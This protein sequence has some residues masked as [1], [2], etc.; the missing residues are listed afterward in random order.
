MIRFNWPRLAL[1]AK[2]IDERT[3]AARSTATSGEELEEIGARTYREV[4]KTRNRRSIETNERGKRGAGGSG[5]MQ[6][7]VTAVAHRN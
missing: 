7:G 6:G 3:R 1:S 5:G 2:T 4:V